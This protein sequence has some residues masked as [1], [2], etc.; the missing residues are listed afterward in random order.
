[1]KTTAGPFVPKLS[2]AHS[3]SHA[4]LPV[5]GGFSGLLHLIQPNAN[6]APPIANQAA[7]RSRAVN[8]VCQ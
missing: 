6:D 2:C 3:I 1:M 4:H 8:A 5:N 7:P